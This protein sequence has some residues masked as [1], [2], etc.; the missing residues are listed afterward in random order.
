MI[1][2]KDRRRAGKLV[3]SVNPFVPKPHTPFQWAAFGDPDELTERLRVIKSGLR[4]LPNV[5]VQGESM[6]EAVLQALLS[7]GDRRVA[8]LARLVDE[9]GNINQALR[10]W[11]ADHRALL[12]R[13]RT[14]ND[15]LP[16]DRV[17]VGVKRAYSWR[18]YCDAT[19]ITATE[20]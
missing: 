3:L 12:A 11:P 1:G 16:W 17:D 6:R 14:F 18:Q 15:F 13:P 4:G 5:E 7:V 10:R 8:E 9:T 20:S 2:W 19:T